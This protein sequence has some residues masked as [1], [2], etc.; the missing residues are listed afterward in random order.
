MRFRKVESKGAKQDRYAI[1]VSSSIK[2]WEPDQLA[3]RYDDD[4][5]NNDNDSDSSV[6][7]GQ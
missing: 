4:D 2:E 6:G 7:G 1:V 5:N 3:P